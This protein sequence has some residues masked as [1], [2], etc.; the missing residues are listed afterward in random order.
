MTD[1]GPVAGPVPEPPDAARHLFGDHLPAAVAYAG[2]LAGDGV[3][4]GHLGPREVPRLWSRHLVNCALL[5]DLVPEGAHVLDVGSGAGLPG[6][7]M[8]VRR[9]DLR[10]TLLE[11]MLRRSAFLVETVERI[12]LADRVRVVRG[13]A[14]DPTVV[15]ELAGQE[16]VVARAVAPMDRLVT[17]CVP[18]LAPRGRLL[19]LKGRSAADEVREHRNEIVRIGGGS[20]TVTELGTTTSEPTW[21]VSVQRRRP[22]SRGRKRR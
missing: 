21:V 12:G 14:D 15:A 18:L 7:P 20:A 3:R 10:V 19:A 8:A 17:W 4:H 6:V 13:R 1:P 2:A 22:P 9:P 16:W 5:T 11:P